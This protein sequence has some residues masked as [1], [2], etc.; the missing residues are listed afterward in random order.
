MKRKSRYN[1]I[2][3]K[4]GTNVLTANTDNV[5]KDVISDIVRQV[6][7]LH[8]EGREI[9]LVSSGAVASGRKLLT[10][11]KDKKDTATRQVMAAVGQPILMRSYAQLFGKENII[12]AQALLSKLSLTNDISRINTRNTLMTLLRMG[13]ITIVNGNDVVTTEELDGIH[14]GDNDNLS[15]MVAEI[16]DADIL[17]IIS[18]IDGLYT[19]DPNL[20][21]NAKLI[22][23][24][25]EINE[26]IEKM[27][28]GTNGRGT[29]GMITKIQAAKL[30]TSSDIT[31]IIA[32][33]NERN[34]LLR[35]ANGESIGTTFL[36]NT[37]NK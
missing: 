27:A 15:G 13:V 34:L 9:I 5:N 37:N 22:P 19:A 6:T 2:V 1:R 10:Q 30:A 24:V 35:L 16:I 33:G 21:K 32:N 3:I 20:D 4:I 17:M 36:P 8:N 12:I 14:F 23:V 25:K 31:V 28:N 26:D 7:Q 29:G 11:L 18:D